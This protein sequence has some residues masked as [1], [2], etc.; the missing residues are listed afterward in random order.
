MQHLP[1]CPP[2]TLFHFH[3]TLYQI[4]RQSD[5]KGGNFFW[6]Q[7]LIFFIL[8]QVF[9]CVEKML[10]KVYGKLSLLQTFQKLTI[11]YGLDPTV[12]IF[13]NNSFL[14]FIGA[15]K[16]DAFFYQIRGF[17]MTCVPPQWIFRRS[18]KNYFWKFTSLKRNFLLLSENIFHAAKTKFEKIPDR[19]FL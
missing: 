5:V 19:T 6:R 13:Q 17:K 14:D 1:D 8:N 7:W 12:Y 11:E 4:W 10:L 16:L 9:S 2:S 3:S 15:I 18:S